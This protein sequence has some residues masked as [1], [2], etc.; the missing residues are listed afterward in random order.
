MKQ[1][2]VR[3]VFTILVA[4]V[5]I[6]FVFSLVLPVAFAQQLELEYPQ[7]PGGAQPPN[8]VR[9]LPN[10]I[11]YM[12]NLG[13]A[14][15]GLAAFVSFVYGGFRYVSSAGNPGALS[16]AREQIKA[17]L[18]GL[19][20]LLGSWLLLTTINPQLVILKIDKD[21]NFS[22]QGVIL[23]AG[24]N[25]GSTKGLREGVD[26]LRVKNTLSDLTNE[27]PGVSIN[28]PKAGSI[29]FLNSST[30]L[31]IVIYKEKDRRGIKVFSSADRVRQQ[32][33]E[34]PASLETDNAGAACVSLGGEQKI[35]SVQLT[36]K[37][38]GV[39]LF[40]GAECSGDEVQAYVGNT[41]TLGDFDNRA[42]SLKIIPSIT[43]LPLF[44]PFPEGTPESD[45]FISAITNK[46]G[47]VLFEK[48]RFEGDGAVF[49]GGKDLNQIPAQRAECIP[50]AESCSQTQ[51]PYCQGFVANE[52][53]SVKV[54][55]QY[56]PYEI[57]SN[58]TI[59]NTIPVNSPSG[60]GVTLF[61]NYD[62]NEQ[63]KSDRNE[64]DQKH[65]GPIN[66]QTDAT[67]ALRSGKPLWVNGSVN[68]GT[69]IGSGDNQ[70]TVSCDRVLSKTRA[71][72]IRVNGD[73]VAV[74]FREDGRAEVF[75]GDDIRLKNNHIG[76][77]EAR[78]LLVIPIK[79][80]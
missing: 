56:L 51:E 74:L 14:V 79:A 55:N 39:Y 7:V 37:T 45:K 68:F 40:A 53:S 28:F 11:K 60:D 5:L 41:A 44:G 75:E 73:Y 27:I 29:R 69:T 4:A 61:G 13:I 46:V 59:T 21:A 36:W 58:Q 16:D 2:R 63:P 15:A 32:G 10:F 50:I 1:K 9:S 34:I 70:S 42:K 80:R 33:G 38:P 57:V 8:E 54:F 17:S 78:Y 67:G 49:L 12:F 31:D 6:A 77:N 64:A 20:L 76:D 24:D 48:E 22:K 72:S 71:S 30:E 18:L 23:F 52:V 62:F 26:F 66:A 19:V 47:V 25:C 3:L 65:C 35:G 43:R